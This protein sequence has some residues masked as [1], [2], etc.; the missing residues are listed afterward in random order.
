MNVRLRV[1]KC[2]YSNI[3]ASYA[4]CLWLSLSR[5]AILSPPLAYSRTSSKRPLKLSRLGG[6]LREVVVYESLDHIGSK[7]C[8][9]SICDLLRKNVPYS[10]R[11]N[12]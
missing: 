2:C 9:I 11:S 1:Y 7:F 3:G 5:G 8:L 12:G 10:I 4:K 6:H